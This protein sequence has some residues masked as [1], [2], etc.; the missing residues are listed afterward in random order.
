MFVYLKLNV[1][2]YNIIYYTIVYNV[3]IFIDVRLSF[4]LR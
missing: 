1:I 3:Y 4:N 2:Y